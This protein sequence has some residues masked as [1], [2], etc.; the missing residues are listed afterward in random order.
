MTERKLHA[1]EIF[2]FLARL[3]VTDI[4]VRNAQRDLNYYILRY[5]AARLYIFCSIIS[6]K[7]KNYRVS[8]MLPNDFKIE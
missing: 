3:T 1:Y 6:L 8:Q 2:N 7:A 4:T 5:I